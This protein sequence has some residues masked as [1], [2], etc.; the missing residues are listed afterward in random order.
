MLKTEN[1]HR[2]Q[3]QTLQYSVLLEYSVLSSWL[4]LTSKK[5]AFEAVNL[6][7]VMDM[8]FLLL[9]FF[10]VTSQFADEERA[11]ELPLPGASEAKNR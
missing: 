10:M 1:E 7:S 6:T 11:L 2:N 3:N 4:T 9:I 8:V 5:V